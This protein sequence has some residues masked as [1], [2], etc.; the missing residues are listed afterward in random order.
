[1]CRLSR[2]V[3]DKHTQGH[4]SICAIPD[5]PI[6][7]PNP[8][9]NWSRSRVQQ[10]RRCSLFDPW[11]LLR[12]RHDFVQVPVW[13]SQCPR[14]QMIHKISKILSQEATVWSQMLDRILLRIGNT[15]PWGKGVVSLSY[16]LPTERHA[17]HNISASWFGVWCLSLEFCRCHYRSRSA[18]LGRK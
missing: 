17:H 4:Y 18:L 11:K 16:F 15:L 2:Q 9:E 12:S 6:P 5:A 10:I 13:T 3:R 1:M 14:L 8:E 7:V